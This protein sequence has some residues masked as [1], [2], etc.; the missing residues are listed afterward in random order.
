MKVNGACIQKAYYMGKQW[1]MRWHMKR[2]KGVMQ[3]Q[4][5]KKDI[6]DPIS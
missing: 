4:R 3:D 6:T 2:E 5:G 1:Q